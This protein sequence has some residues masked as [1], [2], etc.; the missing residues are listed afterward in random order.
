MDLLRVYLN[1]S[2]LNSGNK[3]ALDFARERLQPI[4]EEKLEARHKK[5]NDKHRQGTAY[6]ANILHHLEEEVDE[7]ADAL[8]ANDFDNAIEEIADVINCAEILAAALYVSNQDVAYHFK[9]E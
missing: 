3:K 6:A 7:L 1:G 2:I 5:N 4:K 8:K 9:E